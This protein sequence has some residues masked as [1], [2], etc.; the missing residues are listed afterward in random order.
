VHEW[1]DGLYPE[2][3]AMSDDG[4]LVL[5]VTEAARTLGISRALAYE[6]IARGELP[7][8]RL[9]RRLVVPRRALEALVDGASVAVRSGPSVF[10]EKALQRADALERPRQTEESEPHQALG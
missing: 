1:I 2:E 7:A 10:D 6:L 3:D 5:T 8:L 9:G 4:R